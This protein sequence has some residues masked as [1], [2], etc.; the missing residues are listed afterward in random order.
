MVVTAWDTCKR[1]I[2]QNVEEEL[3]WKTCN[4]SAGFKEAAAGNFIDKVIPED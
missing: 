4:G 1:R 3:Q 2:W